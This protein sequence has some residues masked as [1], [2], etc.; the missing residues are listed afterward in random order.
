MSQAKRCLF[1]DGRSCHFDMEKIPLQTCQL[2]IEAWK[3][4]IA[5]KGKQ[6]PQPQN[7]PQQPPSESQPLTMPGEAPKRPVFYNEGLFE[8]DDLLKDETLDP[9]EYVRL[10]KQQL[11]RMMN[12]E[13]ARKEG[14]LILSLNLDQPPVKTAKPRRPNIP[15]P[16]DI[17]VAVVV[18]TLFG[19][20][21]YTSPA[22][23]RLPEE[24]NNK[25]IKSIFKLTKQKKAGGI[26]LR[27]GDYKIACIRHTKGK[28]AMMIIDA[29]EEFETYDTEIKRIAKILYRP[30]FWVTDLKKITP[31]S[32]FY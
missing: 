9:L 24:I 30:N 20:K 19:K 7:I 12:P 25:V 8:I 32:D 10:R 23:W 22:D 16:R 21:V 27:A 13:K 4:E 18:K 11:D 26:R 17:R 29:D 14:K 6:P 2:C 15:I 1:I 28:F 5:L 3:T 31:K